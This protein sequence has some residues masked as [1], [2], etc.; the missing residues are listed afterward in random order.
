M[1]DNDFDELRVKANEW[2]DSLSID[3]VVSWW[4]EACLEIGYD[5]DIIY[6][7]D[8]LDELFGEMMPTEFLNKLDLRHFNPNNKWMQDSRYGLCTFND[9]SVFERIDESILDQFVIDH[10]LW[11]Q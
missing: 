5:E 9:D 6:S 2:I 4:N 11:N 8:E 3:E 1:T 10:E 7:T